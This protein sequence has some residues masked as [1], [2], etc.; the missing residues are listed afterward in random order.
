MIW[1]HFDNVKDGCINAL[2]SSFENSIS[3]FFLQKCQWFIIAIRL[4]SWKLYCET[5]CCFLKFFFCGLGNGILLLSEFLC[6]CYIHV[7][8]FLKLFAGFTM[9]VG[10]ITSLKVISVWENI[11]L[12]CPFL[13]CK[14]VYHEVNVITTK[15]F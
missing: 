2:L 9:V 8:I 15:A 4:K 10:K 3:V 6:T 1:D 14:V 13:C 12:E 7:Q 5:Y 11:S